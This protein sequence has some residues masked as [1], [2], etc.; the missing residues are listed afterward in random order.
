MRDAGEIQESC[1]RKIAQ[2]QISDQFRAILGC[3]LEQTW[4]EPRLVQMI[5]SPEGHL[6]GRAEGQATEQ[7][8]L[9]TQDDLTRNIN[10]IAQVAALDGDELGFLVGAVAALKRRR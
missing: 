7:V 8:Y 3:L 4:T 9:G 10:G 6:L 1:A 5:L 2:V